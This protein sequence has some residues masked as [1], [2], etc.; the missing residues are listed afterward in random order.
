MISRERIGKVLRYDVPQ[1]IAVGVVFGIA[2]ARIFSLKWVA[3]M[4]MTVVF[5][6]SNYF[7]GRHKGINDSLDYIEEELRAGTEV[8]MK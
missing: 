3:L 8:K 6:L 5:G 4:L 2:D 1:L 7:E